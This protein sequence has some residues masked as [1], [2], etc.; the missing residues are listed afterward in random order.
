MKVKKDKE[1][2]GNMINKGYL[3]CDRTSKGDE[4]Y[5]PFYAVE[6]LL[7][8]IPKD[9]IIWLPF[10]EEW[11]AFYQM[12]IEN[13]YKVIRSC[14]KD[15]QDFF[16]YEPKEKYDIIISNPPF[17]KKDKVLKRLYELNKPFMILLPMNSLQG[18]GRY[19]C[20]KN[21]IQLLSF[22]SRIDYHTNNNFKTYTKGNHFASAYFC[23]N[24]LPKDLIIEKL[25]K[26]DRSLI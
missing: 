12:F 21:G 10:D 5:T 20:F 3:T 24:I 14:L 17:S 6:P 4:V 8:Y 23:K 15:N 26:Y 7:K 25:T 16:N 9:Y 11:S 19:N 13:G 1:V 18:K 22:D 2:R